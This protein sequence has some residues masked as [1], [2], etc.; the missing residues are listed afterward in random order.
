[1]IKEINSPKDVT[2]ENIEGEKRIKALFFIQGRKT[3]SS[4]FRVLNFLPL[5]SK[6]CI[7]S[8]VLAPNPSVQGDLDNVALNGYFRE[9]IRPFSIISR[10]RQLSQT[11]KHDIVYIQKPLIIYPT[12]I[13]ERI[14]TSRKP[15]IF[16]L[17]D[18]VFHYM[19]NLLRF[20]INRIISM[21]NHIVAGNSYIAEKIGVPEKTTIIPTVVDTDHYSER[22][23]PDGQFT[24]G[25]TGVA[26]NLRELRPL[27][28]VLKRVLAETGG[29]LLIVAER[30]SESFLSNLPVEFIKWSPES[31]VTALSMMHVGLMPLSDTPFNR[32]K[33]GFKIIQYQAR[34]IP[35]VA[36]P[37]GANRD[38]VIDGLNGFLANS[39]NEWIDALINLYRNPILRQQMGKAGRERIEKEYSVKAKA[40]ILAKLII[41]VAN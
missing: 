37:L 40:P 27:A 31:E 2:A 41:K 35:V 23:E 21:C 39:E 6:A 4:R 38:I 1:M 10:A 36:T 5:L 18:A 28:S 30:N 8:T 16:D 26:S 11:K 12:T 22:A 32:G 25:W 19:G 29:R 33:C 34:G 7:D 15:S 14:V 17:D 9:F 13:F 24:I 20:K 3:P